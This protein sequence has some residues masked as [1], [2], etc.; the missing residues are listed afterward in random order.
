MTL[1]VFLLIVGKNAFNFL[2]LSM[3][4]DVSMLKMPFNRLRKLLI[5]II[6]W[7]FWTEGNVQFYQMLFPHLFRWSSLFFFFFLVYIFDELHWFIE[8]VVKCWIIPRIKPIQSWGIY[9]LIRCWIWFAKIL[10][11]IVTPVL[12]KN[13]IL[14]FCFWNVFVRIMMA[15]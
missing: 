12:I 2:L 9:I 4:L 1:R 3:M 5:F 11:R 15:S 8:I 6:C 7:E 13:I 10:F 14:S